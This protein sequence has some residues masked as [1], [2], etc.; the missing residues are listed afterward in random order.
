MFDHAQNG[1]RVEIEL[2]DPLARPFLKWAGGKRSL[3]SEIFPRIPIIEGRFIEPFLGA[4]AVSLALPVEIPK[5][6]NDFNSELISVYLAIRD[7]KDELIRELKKHKN[8]QEHFL[9]VREWDRKPNYS[10][11]TSIEKAA[12][13]IYLNKTCF[14]GLYRV[15]SKGEFNVPFGHYKNPELF[16]SVH[17]ERISEILNGVESN[18]KKVAPKLLLKSGDYRK[19]TKLAKPGDFVYLDP[20]YDPINETSAFVSYQKEGFTKDHQIELRDE[21]VR[22]TKLGIPI[23]LSNSDTKFIRKIYS[24]PRLFKIESVQVRRAIGASAA[25]RGNVSEVLVTN[26][27]S[28]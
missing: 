13:F 16:N 25:S 24:E 19:V 23:L 14:N 6:A 4:G 15:N 12:R 10:T 3:L 1:D 9:R 18:G 21:V 2:K 5:I 27:N 11:R 20:P 26:Y 28:I 7:S 17:L 8:T 22:L